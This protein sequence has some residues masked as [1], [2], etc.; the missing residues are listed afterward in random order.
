[1]IPFVLTGTIVPNAVLTVHAD[2]QQRR[3]EYLR[4]IK[5][6]LGYGP[7]YFI[8][9]SEYPV[10]ED[11]FFTKTASLKT[12]QYPKSNGVTR[13]KGYQEFEML[14][15]FVSNHLMED[16]FIK[17]TGRYVY[18]NIGDIAPRMVRQFSKGEIVIDLLFK[19]KK[20]IV[21]LFAVS[22]S[23]YTRYLKGAYQDMDDSL[24]LWAEYVMYPRISQTR[25][26]TFLQPAPVL[27]A[28]TGSMGQSINMSTKGFRP[29]F[30]D[31]KRWLFSMAGMRELWV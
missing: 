31:L 9:N 12:L 18:K 2:F 1:M 19:E 11:S 26:A 27:Q 15:T 22:K 24:G 7:V 29:R 5:F 28:V 6:Y 21:S 3:D 25:A 17:V 30:R 23:Y 20:A 4:A 8:E 14:D 16:S 10:F 13:G